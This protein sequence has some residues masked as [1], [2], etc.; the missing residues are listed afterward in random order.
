M[1]N[2]YSLTLIFIVLLVPYLA[3]QGKDNSSKSKIKKNQSSK[4]KGSSFEEAMKEIEE[5]RKKDLAK[6]IIRINKKISI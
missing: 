1:K 3:G 2:K 4:I 5:V 6:E